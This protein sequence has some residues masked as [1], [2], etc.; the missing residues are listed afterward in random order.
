MKSS[1]ESFRILRGNKMKR[2]MKGRGI[3]SG[4][5]FKN[6]R[7]KCKRKKKQFKKRNPKQKKEKTM[8]NL[9]KL[10]CIEEEKARP[11]LHLHNPSNNPLTSLNQDKW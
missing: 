9:S 4:K 8:K 10:A 11:Q 5:L 7:E 6:E 3:T 2:S 1:W